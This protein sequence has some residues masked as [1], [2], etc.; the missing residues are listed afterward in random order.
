MDTFRNLTNFLSSASSIEKKQ[1]KKRISQNT[2]EVTQQLLNS[3]AVKMSMYSNVSNV[4][5]S[6]TAKAIE[7]GIQESID[8]NM[9]AIYSYID[10]IFS[11]NNISKEREEFWINKFCTIFNIPN[12]L[13]LEEK[14]SL[15]DRQLAIDDSTLEY[16]NFLL[17]KG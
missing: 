4:A 14:K 7:S 8:K 15:I 17:L 5:P 2:D 6:E 9:N 10:E 11:D 1:L 12:D 13:T 16:V 3:S